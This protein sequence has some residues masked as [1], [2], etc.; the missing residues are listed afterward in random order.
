VVAN[1]H[2]NTSRHL[3]ASCAPTCWRPCS[4]IRSRSTL[5][6]WVASNVGDRK[7]THGIRRSS[8]YQRSSTTSTTL[9]C[10]CPNVAGPWRTQCSCTFDGDA[11]PLWR[12]RE[13]EAEIQVT[14][15][16]RTQRCCG[17]PGDTRTSRVFLADPNVNVP[18]LR[19]SNGGW[20]TVAIR[21]RRTDRR[22]S[23]RSST[24]LGGTNKGETTRRTASTAYG[25]TT[26][27]SMNISGDN[28]YRVSS[29]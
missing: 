9:P 18:Q 7:R 4:W 13:R 8:I 1:N 27:I 23:A 12:Y 2:V 14:L 21:P 25:E 11:H 19:S 26:D 20:P 22:T 3:A 10:S 28:D 29:R 15:N 24:A 16:T 5:R 6:D 17:S